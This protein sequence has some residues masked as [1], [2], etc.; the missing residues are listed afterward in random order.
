MALFVLAVEIYF[1]TS[2]HYVNTPMHQFCLCWHSYCAFVYFIKTY[3]I[4]KKIKNRTPLVMYNGL[5]HVY[6]IKEVGRIHKNTK[7]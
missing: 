7:G 5:S 2:I 6:C 1:N 3:N 4:F